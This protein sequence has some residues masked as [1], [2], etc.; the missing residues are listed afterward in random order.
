MV[1]N[2]TINVDTVNGRPETA[3]F[4]AILS[5]SLTEV[6]LSVTCTNAHG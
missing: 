6:G 1:V 5:R 3:A 2:T 4:D